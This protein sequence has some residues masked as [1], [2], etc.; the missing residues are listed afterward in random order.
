MC[1]TENMADSGFVTSGLSSRSQPVFMGLCNSAK[2]LFPRDYKQTG[3]L[4]TSVQARTVHKNEWR[5]T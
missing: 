2:G 1:G 4:P 3:H 5:K